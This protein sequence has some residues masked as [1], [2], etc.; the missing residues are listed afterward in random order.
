MVWP[1][2]EYA[3]DDLKEVLLNIDLKRRVWTGTDLYPVR[4]YNPSGA[5]LIWNGPTTVTV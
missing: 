1:V 5:V 2:K 3:Y 4:W